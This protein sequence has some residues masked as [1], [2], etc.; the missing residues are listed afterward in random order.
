M[1]VL[2]LYIYIYIFIA[3]ICSL[4]CSQTLTIFVRLGWMKY[5]IDLVGLLN[6]IAGT[7]QCMQSEPPPPDGGKPKPKFYIKITLFFFF[8]T[9][10]VPAV[11]F[12]SFVL[13]GL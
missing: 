11:Q 2:S 1:L 8:V 7:V 3:T 6:N 12:Q 10:V 4:K 5:E 13:V 9:I